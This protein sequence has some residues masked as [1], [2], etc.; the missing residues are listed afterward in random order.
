MRPISI[1][2]LEAEI[3]S[4]YE[5]PLRA[6]ATF[7]QMSQVFREIKNLPGVIK[8]SQLRPPTVAAWLRAHPGRSA[9]RDESLLRCWRIICNYAVSQGFLRSSPFDVRKVT[10][11][12]RSDSSKAK[13]K[14]LYRSATQLRDFLR[15]LD[16]EA[17][18]SWQS[19]RLQALGYTYVY[20]GFRK[21]EAL[22]LLARNV[23]FA[24]RTITIEPLPEFD[25]IPKTVKSART[26]PM[27][28]PLED[29]MRVW[30][31]MCGSD[32]LFPGTRLVGPW[33]GGS[34]QYTALAQIKAAAKRA[35][36]P[37]GM[38]ILGARKSLGTNAKA[39]GL[40]KLER[41][42][43]F[44]HTDEG[45]GELYDEEQVETMRPA[46]RKLELFYANGG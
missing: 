29:V 2:R 26:L 41:M 20:T 7:R 9:A 45:T 23:D 19:R 33:T 43:L 27:A 42:L 46:V 37:E 3:M 24:Q 5:P 10:A 8:T 6:V 15:I 25:W 34:K 4:L 44:G 28:T 30:V 17:G 38:T 14:R 32:W 40:G 12:R 13:P 36:I 22:H 16:Q 31:P 11:W 39:M 21:Q 1:D 35:G 18:A